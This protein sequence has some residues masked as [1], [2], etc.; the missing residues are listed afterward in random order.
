MDGKR[1]VDLGELVD[2][3]VIKKKIVSIIVVI[4]FFMAGVAAFLL[5]ITYES[6][7]LV[8]TRNSSKLDISGAAAAMALLGGAGGG[9]ASSTTAYIELM[10]SRS[11]LDPIIADL[12]LPVD[13]KEKL[14]AKKFAKKEL[15]IEN[16]KGTNLISVTA[17]GKTPEEAQQIS[18][19]VVDN[20]LVLMT[21]MNQQTQ[22]LMVKFLNERID[23]AKKESDDASQKLEEF[24][25]TKKVYGPSDQASAQL[26]QMAVFDKAVGDLE[27]QIIGSQAQL[28]SVSAQ[29]DK[30][31]ANLTA[32]NVADN[33]TVQKLRDQIVAKEVEMV[34]LQQRYQDKHPTV[35]AAQQELVQL[36]SSLTNEVSTA[37]A[38]GTATM[39]PV[40]AE[41]MKNKVLA[42]TTIAVASASENA[43]K[44][45][46]D[47]AEK[48]MSQLSED[49]LEYVKFQRDATIKNEIYLNLVKQCEQ[50]KIQQ[51]MESMDI[52]I[53]DPADLPKEPKGPKGFTVVFI[54]G[55]IGI[56]VAIGYVLKVYNKQQIMKV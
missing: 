4:C 11:V 40:Q 52:Q 38:A 25:K 13:K 45:L 19:S 10:K 18:Q 48:N 6:T 37:V 36:Q 15:D 41:L 7:T 22:S 12:D 17:K 20:F 53:V 29:L 28:D 51:A 16:T 49:V 39:N 30:Q 5:P 8:Q 33:I 31:N 42:S 21:K 1:N 56:L 55:L 34:G 2:I 32:Y 46:Q 27:V 50:A 24:S 43:V 14:D 47:K 23:N 54:G 3:V 35:I 26:K 44:T 9:A